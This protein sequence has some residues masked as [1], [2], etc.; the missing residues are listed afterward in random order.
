MA[1]I[2]LKISILNSQSQGLKY[3]QLLIKLIP[4]ELPQMFKLDLGKA[5]ELEI[6]L[7][8]SIRS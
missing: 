4:G 2:L 6:K 7:K 3:A 8:I 5:E 1:L